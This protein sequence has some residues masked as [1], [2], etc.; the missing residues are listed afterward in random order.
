MRRALQFGADLVPAAALWLAAWVMGDVSW[1][2]ASTRRNRA[3]SC[4]LAFVMGLGFAAVLAHELNV[5]W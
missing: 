4:L 3:L 1:P 2:S 5:L